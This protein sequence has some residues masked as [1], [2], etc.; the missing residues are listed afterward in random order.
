MVNPTAVWEGCAPLTSAYKR[1]MGVGMAT[2]WPQALG[3]PAFAIGDPWEA[4]GGSPKDL[5]SA[6]CLR[7]IPAFGVPIVS[8]RS[9]WVAQLS[10]WF[11]VH[12]SSRNRYSNILYAIVSRPSPR[13]SPQ[14]FALAIALLLRSW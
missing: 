5:V 7:S 6:S 14:V 13:P 12:G 9:I 1:G 2:P 10:V 11:A 3:S 4:S 8:H